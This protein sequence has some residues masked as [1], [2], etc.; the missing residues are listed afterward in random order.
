MQ[1][2]GLQLDV[3][4]GGVEY[5]L[6]RITEFTKE[7]A[8]QGA[9][10]IVFPECA[11]TGYC[12]ESLEEAREFAERIPNTGNQDRVRKTRDRHR[13]LVCDLCR[14]IRHKGD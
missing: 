12:F 9:E 1:I 10:L 3:Q 8:V 14:G 4:L 11:S 5:N 2:A 6:D 7:A 13:R